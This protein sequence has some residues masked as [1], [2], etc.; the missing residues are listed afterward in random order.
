MSGE[1]ARV[2]GTNEA[3]KRMSW[4]EIKTDESIPANSFQFR[5]PDG[6]IDSFMIVEGEVV[7]INLTKLG[8]PPNW[9]CPLCSHVNPCLAQVCEMCGLT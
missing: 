3:V 6:R 5:H 7:P 1:G 9:S 4:P 2:T 8:D